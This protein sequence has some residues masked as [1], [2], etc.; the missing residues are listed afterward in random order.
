MENYIGAFNRGDLDGFT[1]FYDENVVLDLGGKKTIH[2]RE[3]IRAFYREVFVKIR[4]T[5]IV[6]Q[7]VLDDDGLA[8]I[9]STEF[10]ALADW[11]DFMAGPI[12]AGQ[13]IHIESF[14][15]YTFGADGKFTHIR[16]TRSKG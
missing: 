13:S 7:L 1:R 15:F 14:I 10:H 5:L 6:D 8:C 9:I 12:E 2:T 11:P 3:G 16:T 4:E